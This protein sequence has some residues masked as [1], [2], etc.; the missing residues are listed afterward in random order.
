[1][2]SLAGGMAEVPSLVRVTRNRGFQVGCCA[3]TETGV[4]VG[5]AQP[6]QVGGKGGPPETT[7]KP[8]C[9]KCILRDGSP[10]VGGGNIR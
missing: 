10:G 7:P 5:T 4:G 8:Q 2:D 3:A 1:M 9:W 6:P